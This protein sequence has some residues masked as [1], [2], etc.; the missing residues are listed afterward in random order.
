MIT[1]LNVATP[2]VNATVFVLAASNVLPGP[3]V[4]VSVT[5]LASPVTVLLAASFTV[6]VNEPSATPAVPSPTVEMTR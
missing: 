1:L 6:T 4:I 3:A 2:L 5:L